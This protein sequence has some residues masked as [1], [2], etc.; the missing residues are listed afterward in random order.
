MAANAARPQ[1]PLRTFQFL[2]LFC[3]HSGHRSCELASASTCSISAWAEVALRRFHRQNIMDPRTGHGLA[4]Q[5][6]EIGSY[7]VSL[8]CFQ[9]DCAQYT[10]LKV[11]LGSFN[12]LGRVTLTPACTDT[13]VLGSMPHADRNTMNGNGNVSHLVWLRVVVDLH[14]QLR[15]QCMVQNKSRGAVREPQC[16]SHP[17]LARNVEYLTQQTVLT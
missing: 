2:R 12:S 5:Y 13:C 4:W 7:I 15:R 14:P 8:P 17:N 10:E 3:F 11:S 6:S 16:S 9:F 1:P